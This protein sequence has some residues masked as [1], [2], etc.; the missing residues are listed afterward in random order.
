MIK[1]PYVVDNLLTPAYAEAIHHDA[2]NFLFYEY[3]QKTSIKDP[4]LRFSNI[5]MEDEN[6]V[7]EGQMVCPIWSPPGA[8]A[9]PPFGK[10]EFFIRPLTLTIMD[11]LKQQGITVAPQKI[12]FNLL[13][14][15]NFPESHYNIPH[16]DN[17]N[18]NMFSAVYYI[19]DSDGDTF[20]FNEMV[21]PDKLPDKLTV[22][23]RISPK[24]NRLV[25][26][27]SDRFH[28]SSNPRVTTER[29]IINFVFET[30]FNQTTLDT[31]SN[32]SN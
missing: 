27:E 15:T 16:A 21:L 25:I 18:P 12:K 9:E 20:V 13:R 28:A 7:D 3:K 1:T 23:Q 31:V 11:I 17:S 8:M 26:F 10:Y 29:L 6:T 22:M 2:L 24:K 32:A 30:V 19:N 14:K 4:S 5:V